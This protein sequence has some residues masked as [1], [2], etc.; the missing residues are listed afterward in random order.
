MVRHWLSA[1]CHE[2]Q[3]S[4]QRLAEQPQPG[5]RIEDEQPA[6]AA[7]FK[8]GSIAAVTDGV[9]SGASDTAPNAPELD[10][11]FPRVRH[12]ASSSS[13]ASERA[14]GAICEIVRWV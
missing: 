7:D 5:P 8:A 12:V 10:G 13:V 3:L 4:H 11:E 1:H 2:Q 9:R 6:A 14:P